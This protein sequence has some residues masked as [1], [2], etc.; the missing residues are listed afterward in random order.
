MHSSEAGYV[1]AIQCKPG[2]L[3]WLARLVL[4]HWLRSTRAD[5]HP[6][7]FFRLSCSDVVYQHLGLVGQVFLDLAVI[8]NCFGL[9]MVYMIVI[10]DVLVGDSH[11]NEGLLSAAC[12]DRR[13]VLAVVTL[14][15][16]APMLSARWVG[17]L[18][19]CMGSFLEETAHSALQKAYAT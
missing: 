19:W 13:I 15:V 2:A 1:A 16:L 6:A 10:G 9:M 7:S 14:L 12:G 11:G 17:G 3:A 4:W 8:V 5:T 18:F